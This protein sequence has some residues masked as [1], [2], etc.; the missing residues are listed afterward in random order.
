MSTWIG[1]TDKNRAWDLLCSAKSHYD[2]VIASGRLDAAAS[3][4]AT[5]QL[6][7]CESSDWFWW[8]GDYNPAAAV[9]SFDRLYRSNLANLYQMLQLEPP[10]QLNLPISAGNSAVTHDGT[11]R[12]A[13]EPIAII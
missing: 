5:A 3:A 2:L 12:R 1:D 6:A 13:N 4:A 8:F 11:M 7:I 9:A 10:T